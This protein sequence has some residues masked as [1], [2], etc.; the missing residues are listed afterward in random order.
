MWSGGSASFVID[1]LPVNDVL[2]QRHIPPSMHWRSQVPEGHPAGQACSS[3]RLCELAELVELIWFSVL[4]LREHIAAGFGMR[5][6]RCSIYGLRAQ[7]AL[8][9]EDILAADM[10]IGPRQG[11]EFTLPQGPTG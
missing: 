8:T 7:Q 11:D 6:R 4:G 1:L 9:L 10:K 2:F 3:I 5:S